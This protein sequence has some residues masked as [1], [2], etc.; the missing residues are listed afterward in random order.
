[1]KDDQDWKHFTC[2]HLNLQSFF[3]AG[4]GNRIQHNGA[5]GSMNSKY[6]EMATLTCSMQFSVTKRK[7]G[8][9]VISQLKHGSRNLK[10][11]FSPRCLIPLLCKIYF[12][13][14]RQKLKKTITEV[15]NRK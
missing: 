5:V 4:F 2:F 15:K 6:F 13:Q 1:M 8:F 3:P 9:W 11:L 10:Q 12:N 7:L 14:L